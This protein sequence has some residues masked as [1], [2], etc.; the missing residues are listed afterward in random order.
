[1]SKEHEVLIGWAS[2]DIT[3]ARPV[4]LQGQHCVR[5]SQHVNDPL[6]VT[7]LAIESTGG[8]AKKEQA[9]MVS[10]DLV[11][12]REVIIKQCRNCVKPKLPGLDT[13]K[14]FFSSTHTHTGPTLYEGIFPEQG[15]EVMTPTECADF[16]VERTADCIVRAWE[17]RGQGGF[18]WGFGQ[19]VVGHNRRI[20]YFDGT[21]KMYGNTDDGNFSHIEG[22]EDHS[23]D[24]LF[25]WD[26]NQELTGIVINLA[27]PSQVTEGAS[28][29]SA[30]FWHETRTEIRKRH[31]KDLFVLPQCSPAGDQSPHLLL[32]KK[33]EARMRELR[34]ISER[35][36]IANRVADAV[37]DVLPA[38][39]DNIH[40]NLAFRH[41][42]RTIKLPVRMVTNEELRHAKDECL[43][44]EKEEPS[45]DKETSRQFSFLPRNEAV[46]ERYGQQKK[47][48]YLPMELHAI[49]LGDI[50]I[51]T[52]RFELFL[53]FGLRIKARSSALQTFLVQLAGGGSYLPTEKAV[54]A[55][56]YGAEIA[57]NLVGPEGGQE[58][59][60]QTVELIDQMWKDED[61]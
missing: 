21:S 5:I 34:G 36:E 18:S 2:K 57:S 30:D 10:C 26:M 19:A 60:N 8:D 1:M 52:N 11:N 54:A 50:A 23:V 42:V 4:M 15:P 33:A 9:V 49:R 44:I 17:S 13:E 58:L 55:K 47:Q 45:S 25:T 7:A 22:Y 6:T 27:C 48:P 40:T 12:T 32:H 39:K 56:S 35:Q 53:D 59:V 14:I 24:M 3:P 20:T 37:D 16:F 61:L 41:V 31:S 43:R 46:I 38:V 51:A 28:Y 29:V